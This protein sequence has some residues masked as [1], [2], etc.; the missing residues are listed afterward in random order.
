MS[1][2]E[3]LKAERD[4]LKAQN[5]ALM[6]QSRQLIGDLAA[7]KRGGVPDGGI[8]GGGSGA[9]TRAGFERLDPKARMAFIKSGGTLKG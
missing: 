2:I 9:I 8:S 7:L 5:E 1:E 4:K 6:E 3:H